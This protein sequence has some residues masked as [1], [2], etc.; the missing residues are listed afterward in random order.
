MSGHGPQARGIR[1]FG[2]IERL[3]EVLCKE[4]LGV[5]CL[6]FSLYFLSLVREVRGPRDMKTPNVS[7]RFA[8]LSF[9]LI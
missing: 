2:R 7:K 6:P 1:H 3:L 4:D 8:F 9:G 5:G